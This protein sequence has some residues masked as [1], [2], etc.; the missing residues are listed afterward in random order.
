[1]SDTTNNYNLPT[2]ININGKDKAYNVDAMVEHFNKVGR[3]PAGITMIFCTKSL[4]MITCFGDNL[5]NKV[6]RHGGIFEL[7]TTFVCKDAGGVIMRTKAGT[8]TVDVSAMQIELDKMKA[9]LE[10]LKGIKTLDQVKVID[11]DSGSV[12]LNGSGSTLA[13]NNAEVCDAELEIV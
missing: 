2:T 4:K 11:T 13:L 3:L 1:M 7:L 6:R 5:H 10:H 9:E 8:Q 12:S